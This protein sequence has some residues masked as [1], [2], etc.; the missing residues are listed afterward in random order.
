MR[1]QTTS[2]TVTRTFPPASSSL[3][4]QRSK[5]STS[6]NIF[7]RG[8][9]VI[10]HPRLHAQEGHKIGNVLGKEARLV[11]GLGIVPAERRKVS[12]IASTLGIARGAGD[13]EEFL[14]RVARGGNLVVD[15]R[16]RL[17]RGDGEVGGEDMGPGDARNG[18][19]R[20][21][22]RLVVAVAQRRCKGKPMLAGA[23]RD[24]FPLPPPPNIPTW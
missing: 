14:G 22:Q 15:A 24:P 3:R 1:H 4:Y 6:S 16:V 13:V 5:I 2:T 21:T 12:S 18:A 11:S 23:P 8:F 10:V 9:R 20:G 19:D 17:E 7:S